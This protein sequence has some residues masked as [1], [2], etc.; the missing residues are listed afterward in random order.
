ML[1][2]SVV[3]TGFFVRTL[4]KDGNL[5]KV[6]TFPFSWGTVDP[7]PTTLEPL[8]WRTGISPSVTWIPKSR[9]T[10]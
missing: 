4:T 2:L 8:D 5:F 10:P 9:S 7:T 6:T 1:F 3:I